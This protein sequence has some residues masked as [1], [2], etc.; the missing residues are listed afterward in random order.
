[1]NVQAVINRIWRNTGV[2]IRIMLKLSVSFNIMHVRC[3][4][5][6]MIGVQ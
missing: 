5:F 4:V 6:N 3:F 2:P 1:V